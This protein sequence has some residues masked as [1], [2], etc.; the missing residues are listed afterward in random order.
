[1]RYSAR[2]KVGKASHIREVIYD[3]KRWKLLEEKRRIALRI[4]EILASCGYTQTLVHGSVARGDVS[5]KSDVDVVVVD[6]IPPS[7]IELC[8]E[9]N[10]LYVYSRVIVQPTPA[11]TPKVYI[12]LDLQELVSVTV[13]LA[14][15][16]IVEYEFYKFSGSLG[17]EGIRKN[18]RVAGVN[19]KLFMIEP[20]PRGHVEYSILGIEYVAARKLGVSIEVVKD[21]VEALRRRDST[22]RTGLFIEKEVPPDESLESVIKKLCRENWMFRRVLK[23]AC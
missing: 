19:K 18:I 9:R 17:L 7:L 4:M 21:R 12:Y 16:S 5:E 23:D 13:P 10:G 22:G 1:M 11:H 20:T 8:L 3:D 6:T 2:E 15:L 14:H